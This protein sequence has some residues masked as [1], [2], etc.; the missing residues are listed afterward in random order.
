[1]SSDSVP[2][3]AGVPRPA[4][5]VMRIAGRPGPS[6]VLRSDRDNTL[7]RSPDAT[8]VV[9]DRMA[10]RVHAAVRFDPSQAAWLLVDLGSRNGTCLD[11]VDVTSAVIA[12][13]GVIRVGTS[14]LSFKLLPAAA[15]AGPRDDSGRFVRRGPVSELE[16][17]VLRRTSGGATD[18]VRRP[19]LL[20]QAS[21][22]LLAARSGREVI[23]I[24][25]ALAAEHAG[26]LGVGWFQVAAPDRLEAVCIAPP[27]SPV[28]AVLDV[29][30]A[31]LVAADGQ[32][33]WTAAHPDA[34]DAEIVCVPIMDDDRVHAALAAAAAPGG[35]RPVDFDFLVALASLASAACSGHAVPRTKPTPADFDSNLTVD[36]E[37]VL[38]LADHEV[39]ADADRGAATAIPPDEAE[40][41]PPRDPTGPMELVL[42][43]TDPSPTTCPI[44][45][46]V[47]ESATLRLADWQRGLVVEALRRSGGRLPDAACALGISLASLR[48]LL[49]FLGLWRP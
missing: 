14:E 45:S 19:L 5:L 35:I 34:A 18:D 33:V 8:I 2:T 20:Y 4:A 41:G 27:G 16:G 44:G 17:S 31:R 40:H 23:E 11:G 29:A 30:T 21:I 6:F 46:T 15:P 24:A 38:L 32:A 22:R 28:T 9:A 10:S 49:D 13:G 25:L 37:S 36:L 42:P 47:A 43:E 39:A 12:D 3:P 1:M 7:G 26:T 48:R